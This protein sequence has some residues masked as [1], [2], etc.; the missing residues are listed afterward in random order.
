[1]AELGTKFTNWMRVWGL[2]VAYGL[3]WGFVHLM[4]W[5]DGRPRASVQDE[6]VGSTLFVLWGIGALVTAIEDLSKRIG[7]PRQ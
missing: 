6:I 4:D 3:L 7:P 1:M 5:L 2:A